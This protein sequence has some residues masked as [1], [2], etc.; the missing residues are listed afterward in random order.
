MFPEA[1]LPFPF[2]GFAKQTFGKRSAILHADGEMLLW[3]ASRS[4]LRSHSSSVRK[5]GFCLSSTH[6]TPWTLS[7]KLRSVIFQVPKQVWVQ[8]CQL[9]G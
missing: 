3:R 4:I 7:P 2:Q 9:P 5:V 6:L 1:H 8:V